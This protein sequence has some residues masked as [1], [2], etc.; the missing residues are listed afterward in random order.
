MKTLIV[1]G[2]KYGFTEECAL[3]LKDALGS[4]VVCV[5]LKKAKIENLESYQRILIGGS[6]YA[7]MIR[8]EVKV[9]CESHLPLLLS[10]EIGIFGSC[11]LPENFQQS[12]NDN[13]PK[14]LVAHAKCIS[15]FG[16][17]FRLSKMNFFE[18]TLVKMISKTKADNTGPQGFL[19]HEFQMF[20]KNF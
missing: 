17:E 7:G 15:C 5:N 10:K 19:E 4:N 6:L 11:G 12:I 13:L 20:V 9:F 18:K 1:Y 8:K 14:E 16:G 2:S 3:R